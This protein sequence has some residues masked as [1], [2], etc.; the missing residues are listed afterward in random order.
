MIKKI[1]V[2][3]CCCFCVTFT[4]AKDAKYPIDTIALEEALTKIQA[5][6]KSF[7]PNLNIGDDEKF[8]AEAQS[9]LLVWFMS[10]K[11]KTVS[12]KDIL[13]KCSEI[14]GHAESC[15]DFLNTYNMY[16][17]HANF[18]MRANSFKLQNF[19]HVE[20]YEDREFTFRD[21]VSKTVKSS[22]YTSNSVIGECNKWTGYAQKCS[23]YLEKYYTQKLSNSK[24][25]ETD[26]NYYG[27]LLDKV[28][29]GEINFPISEM[30]EDCKK[31]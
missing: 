29:T 3:I 28:Q 18:C 31:S 9:D 4:Y 5:T 7:N 2:F 8:I 20:G 11:K 25:S 12:A 16:L 17:D 30:E 1:C 22:F 14:V 27:C 19:L 21:C 6:S 23:I 15:M 10:N 13:T 26:K 24:I